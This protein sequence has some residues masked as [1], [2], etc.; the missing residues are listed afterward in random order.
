MSRYLKRQQDKAREHNPTARQA[1]APHFGHPVPRSRAPQIRIP[2]ARRCPAAEEPGSSPGIPLEA[3]QRRR[4]GNPN[5]SAPHCSAA[6]G[7]ARQN[8]GSPEIGRPSTPSTS[9]ESEGAH[10]A[11]TWKF[12][13]CHVTERKPTIRHSMPVCDAEAPAR[14]AV[15]RAAPR[16]HWAK[17]G[18]HPL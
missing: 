9:A 6:S 14:S 15:I 17:A 10:A 2:A 12:C 7:A 16:H 8:S 11:R 4:S 13:R 5:S 3:A 1:R 18:C